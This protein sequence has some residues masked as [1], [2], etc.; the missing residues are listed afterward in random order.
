MRDKNDQIKL[1]QDD[2]AV[3]SQISRCQS[4]LVLQDSKSK[5]VQAESANA[6][7]QEK[8]EALEKVLNNTTC[9]GTAKLQEAHKQLQ[10]AELSQQR[11][12][13]IA[14]HFSSSDLTKSMGNQQDDF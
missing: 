8:L 7:L 9:E 3:K 5:L 2:L 1:L 13:K 10:Q 11:L 14:L 4:D 6:R 12:R